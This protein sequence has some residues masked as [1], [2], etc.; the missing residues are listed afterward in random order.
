MSA[1]PTCKK[2]A[3]AVQKPAF[4]FIGLLIAVLGVVSQF[5]WDSRDLSHRLVNLL[6][7]SGLAIVLIL[8]YKY[9]VVPRLLRLFHRFPMKKRLGWIFAVSELIFIVAALL[10]V[11]G[12]V[13]LGGD[14]PHYLVLSQSIA[15]DFDLNV[16]NQYARDEYREFS[17]TRLSH[18]ARVGKGFKRWFSYGH[19][20]GLSLTLSPFFL[21]KIPSPLLYFLIR[22]WLGLFGALLAVLV[23]L[24][25]L[26]L[27]RAPALSLF[28]TGA[29]TFTAP[30]F[31]HSIHIFAE[32]QAALIIVGALFLLLWGNKEKNKT[33]LMAGFLLGLPIFWGLKFAIFTAMLT[34]LFFL[35]FTFRE[36]NIKKGLLLCIFPIFFLL[37]FLAFLWSAYGNLDPMSLY[38]GVMTP[39]QKQ[40]YEAN[41]EKI[42]LQKRV[43]TLIGFFADQRDGLF[44]YNPFYLFFIPGLILALKKWRKYW[45]HLLIASSAFLYIAFIGYST[46]RAGYCPQARYLTPASWALLMLAIIYRRES[47]NLLFKRLFLLAPIAGF[48]IALYQLFSPFTLYQGVT[49]QELNRPGLMFQEWGNIF[50]H[51]EKWLPSFVKVPGNFSY[52]PNLLFFVFLIVFT[53]AALRKG[54][55]KTGRL[56]IGGVVSGFVL[57]GALAC[58]VLFPRIPLYNPILQTEPAKTPSRIYGESAFPT[59]TDQRV[60]PLAG[61]NSE[62]LTLS[63]TEAAPYLMIGIENPDTLP[64]QIRHWLFDEA[65]G[66]IAIPANGQTTIRIIEPLFIKYR[67]L[68]FYRLH[69]TITPAPPAD[70]RLQLRVFPSREGADSRPL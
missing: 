51:P 41:M 30:V 65:P 23:Y 50:I 9:R 47:R 21:F 3:A 62:T 54:G 39:E 14:E 40:A 70:S 42:P 20:P 24:S 53:A 44:P 26:R 60:F 19:L 8:I 1:N 12:G 46:V 38:N 10:I 22:A 5:H 32:L 15:R 63:T 64:Y 45:P 29:Y 49:H 2:Y 17:E 6:I 57:T 59:R 36:K 56:P 48:L 69:L 16:F 55:K 31:F 61:M 33:V 25:S 13:K 58:F 18:H 35:Q 28:I 7:I 37:L 67:G 68:V 27:F 4:A 11:Q 52:W 43:E 34:G 66:E